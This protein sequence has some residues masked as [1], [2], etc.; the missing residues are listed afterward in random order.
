MSDE[1]TSEE[2]VP[3]ADSGEKTNNVVERSNEDNDESVQ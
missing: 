2:N 3:E 1:K